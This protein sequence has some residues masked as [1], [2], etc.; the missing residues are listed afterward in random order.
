MKI[1]V[2]THFVVKSVK[3]FRSTFEGMP[4]V[5]TK[6]YLANSFYD[7]KVPSSSEKFGGHRLYID[8]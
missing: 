2:G 7:K 5:F 1:L 6:W 3:K 4:K 8:L